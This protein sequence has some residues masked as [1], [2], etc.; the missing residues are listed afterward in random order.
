MA[1]DCAAPV[2]R[3]RDVGAQVVHR[4]LDLFPRAVDACAY[5]GG[6]PARVCHLFSLVKSQ[7][8]AGAPP[9]RDAP[10]RPSPAGPV[11][12]P[13]PPRPALAFFHPSPVRRVPRR[14]RITLPS[15]EQLPARP[16]P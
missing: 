3:L 2:E 10:I 4:L 11:L 14:R 7:F 13:G 8:P 1:A 12:S 15:P 6:I 5:R 9:G 16:P